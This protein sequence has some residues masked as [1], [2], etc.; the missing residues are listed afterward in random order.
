[1]RAITTSKFLKKRLTFYYEIPKRFVQ[2]V[3]EAYFYLLFRKPIFI[4][5][6]AKPNV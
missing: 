6:E 5:R 1:M 3:C 2:R 4:K